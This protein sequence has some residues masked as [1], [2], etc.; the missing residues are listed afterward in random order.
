MTSRRLHSSN[1]TASST[2]TRRFVNGS[3]VADHVNEDGAEDSAQASGELQ[4]A[5]TGRGASAGCL[6]DP[7]Q[8]I[9]PAHQDVGERVAAVRRVEALREQ[10]RNDMRTVV[11][12]LIWGV[13]ATRGAARGLQNNCQ[14]AAPANSRGP[15][16]GALR[17]A[18]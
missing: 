2:R 12:Q 7:N 5:H 11:G 16:A 3:R 18:K 1:G 4:G 15:W 8:E 6:G 10:G 9:G 14:S 17:D 13:V